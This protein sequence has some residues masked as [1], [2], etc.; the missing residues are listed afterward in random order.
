MKRIILFAALILTAAHAATIT[1]TPA[2]SI[3]DATATRNAWFASNFGANATIQNLETFEA[4]SYGPFTQLAAG[5]GTFSVMQGALPSFSNGTRN[6]E[7]TVLNNS[8]T[9]FFGRYD[10]TPGGNN[11]L[12]SND[13]TKLQLSTSLTTL[14]FF[15]TDV[16]DVDGSLRIQTADGTSATNFAATGADGNLY[17]VGITSSGPIGSI[18]WINNSQND[19][20]GLDDFG[21]AKYNSSTPEPATSHAAGTGLLIL[22]TSL[23][24]RGRKPAPEID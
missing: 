1:I 23:L 9:P 20:F 3:V 13:I 19:G 14:F 16:N 21:T 2:G 12:D 17:F 4:V 6:N 18:Q 7:F 24:I 11:W 15:I 8:N 10:T 5:P 22:A